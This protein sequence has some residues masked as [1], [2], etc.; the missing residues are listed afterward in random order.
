[1]FNSLGDQISLSKK[2]ELEIEQAIREGRLESGERLPTENQLCQQFSVSRTA[3]REALSKLSARGL[4]YVRKGSGTYVNE[5]S[6]EK[7][8]QS[9]NLFF[10]LSTAPDLVMDT[11]NTR[12]ILEPDIAAF[13]ATVRTDE[14]VSLLEANMK[15]MIDCA[16]G[17]LENEALI[18]NEFHS[19][20]S[21]AANNQVIK[22]LMQPV[23]SLS[24]KYRKEVYVKRDTVAKEQHKEILIKHHQAVVDAI[25]DQDPVKARE[26]MLIHLNVAK[27]NYLK[28]K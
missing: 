15:R 1:M 24:A 25:K 11:I 17:D 26:S 14:N 13:A 19:E 18:D 21:Q 27:S 16:I 7:A 28:L 2:I 8:G 4:L 22:L 9:L 23:Y 12:V 6:F 20:I 5:I 3:V 10:E